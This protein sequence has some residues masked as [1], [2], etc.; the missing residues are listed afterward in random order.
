[1]WKTFRYIALIYFKALWS[2]RFATQAVI[3]TFSD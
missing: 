3:S 2:G 1:M